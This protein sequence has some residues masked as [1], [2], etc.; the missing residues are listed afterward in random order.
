M[1]EEYAMHQDD[2]HVFHLHI[3]SRNDQ[4]DQLSHVKHSSTGMESPNPFLQVRQFDDELLRKRQKV[5]SM[6]RVSDLS[7]LAWSLPRHSAESLL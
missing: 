1:D 6:Q 2:D 7:L 5:I 3:S 4:S